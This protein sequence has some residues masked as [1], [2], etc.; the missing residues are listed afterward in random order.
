MEAKRTSKIYVGEPT[1]EEIKEVF[2]RS[3][4]VADHSFSISEGESHDLESSEDELSESFKDEI[5]EAKQK[6]KA[7]V[8][9]TPA[10]DLP[11]IRVFNDSDQISFSLLLQT[12]RPLEKD[13]NNNEADEP[14]GIDKA[15]N[16]PAPSLDTESYKQI[17]H[18]EVVP[19]LKRVFRAD[20]CKR[21]LVLDEDD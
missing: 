2:L 16:L 18:L 7:P 11:L 12:K 15:Q 19:E 21:K 10:Q 4:E 17:Y 6:K 1:L 8:Q 13:E 20:L 9:E 5:E 3:K 14:A